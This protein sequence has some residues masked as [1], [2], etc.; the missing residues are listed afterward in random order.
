MFWNLW[1]T[2]GGICPVLKTADMDIPVGV[3][4]D[5]KLFADGSRVQTLE[6]RYQEVNDLARQNADYIVDLE[7]AD[8]A[9]GR[10][11]DDLDLR[12]QALE[13]S[14]G[15]QVGTAKLVQMG[16]EYAD[17]YY[18]LVGKQVFLTFGDLSAISALLTTI[19]TI[20]GLPDDLVIPLTRIPINVWSNANTWATI[21]LEISKA[22]NAD[23]DIAVINDILVSDIT[24]T[25][26][27]FSKLPN[28]SGNYYFHYAENMTVTLVKG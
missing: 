2:W 26:P 21:V 22:A 27:A 6:T 1:R 4:Q 20:T 11:I 28:S 19:Y 3:A 7:H 17:I 8:I 12:V 10:D 25:T 15:A 16:T 13:Q 24:S 5:G 23:A 14:G 9:I 18:S